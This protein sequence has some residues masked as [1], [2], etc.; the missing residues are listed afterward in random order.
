MERHRLLNET[1]LLIAAFI[2][3]AISIIASFLPFVPGP[4]LVWAI[5]TIYAAL[6][7]FQH[8]GVPG[9]VI[10]T[11][12]MILGSTTSWWVQALGMKAQGGSCLAVIGALIGGLVGTFAIQIPFLGTLIGIVAGSLLFEFARVREFRQALRT[13]S[14]ALSS[15]L[16]V[17]LIEIVL[18]LVMLGVF[19]L[20]LLL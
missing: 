5:A 20:S 19:I 1:L 16:L 13:G 18:S 3:M 2:L 9:V 7:G 12:L 10:M 15:Y 17:I 11:A 8:V 6:T 14:A 4:A